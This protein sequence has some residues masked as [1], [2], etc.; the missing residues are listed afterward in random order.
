M[1]AAGIQ[2]VSLP[3]TLTAALDTVGCCVKLTT[4]F[5]AMAIAS[6]SLA[7]PIVPASLITKSSAI[8]RS[9]ALLKDIF[10][11]A[12]P[13]VAVLKLNFVVLTEALKSPSDTASIPAATVIASVP[14]PSSGAMKLIT[15]NL[16][17][18]A[19]S[20]SPAANVRVGNLSSEVE[21]CFSVSPESATCVSV[22][23]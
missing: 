23:S 21:A 16:S 1:A 11:V 4:P 20:L 3:A 17:S 22:I 6:V 9:P 18:A 19:I 14:A 5:E 8:V 15:P 10:S 12:T 2:I 7:D 13:E